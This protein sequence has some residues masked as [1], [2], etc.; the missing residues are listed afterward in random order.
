MKVKINKTTYAN[1]EIKKNPGYWLHENNP[2]E[3]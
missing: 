3:S 1:M 2:A